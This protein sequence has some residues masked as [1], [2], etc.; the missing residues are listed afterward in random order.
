MRPLDLESGKWIYIGVRQQWKTSN[1]VLRYDM[2]TGK[3]ENTGKE[4]GSAF[5][6]RCAFGYR[7]SMATLPPV[8]TLGLQDGICD[9]K[10]GD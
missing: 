8:V 7:N 1:K 6:M 4:L 2:D 3:V 10:S 9:S 5:D